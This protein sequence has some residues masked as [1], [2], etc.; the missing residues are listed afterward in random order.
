VCAWSFGVLATVT[1]LAVVTRKVW[2]LREVK[3]KTTLFNSVF[4]VCIGLGD[5]M[6]GLYLIGVSVADTIY[7]T[8]YCTKRFDW[9]NSSYC[10]A[11]GLLSTAGSSLSLFFMTCLSL[12]RVHSIKNIFSSRRISRTS[13]VALVLVVLIVLLLAAAIVFI[14]ILEN[15]EDY[16][17]N[18]IHYGKLKLFIG[19]P[20]KQNH[21]RILEQYYGRLKDTMVTWKMTRRLVGEMFTNDHG[22]I[23]GS[24][25]RFYGNSGVCLF[26]YIVDDTDPQRL[27][28]LIVLTF[29]CFLCILISVS[30]IGMYIL[31]RSSMKASGT[32]KSSDFERKVS[33]I[34]VTDLIAWVPFII[35]CYLHFFNTYDVS[36]FYGIFSIVILP[37][38]SVI[39][40]LIYDN[41]YSLLVRLV[42]KKT[43]LSRVNVPQIRQKI[44][45]VLAPRAS[46]KDDLGNTI[47][48]KDVAPALPSSRENHTITSDV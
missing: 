17:L 14:P 12:Y 19:A 45:A 27:F 47:S 40:P 15:F 2:S 8:S 35:L 10:T 3:I 18:G 37:V 41:T 23:L 38:N 5:T 34:I 32:K 48:L 21:I 46:T 39:N 24:D 42:I 28:S 25:R 7:S 43:G 6:I 20:S 31:S 1:N 13:Q 26:K 29:N 16:F 44:L 22:G 33:I 36:S 30:Y 4:V 9:L 11:L